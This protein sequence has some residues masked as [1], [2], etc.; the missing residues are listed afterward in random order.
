MWVLAHGGINSSPSL[1]ISPGRHQ[2]II[3]TN[4]GVLLIG[5]LGTNFNGILIDSHAFSFKKWFWKCH[6]WI[7]GI[8]SREGWV[9]GNPCCLVVQEQH[10]KISRSDIYIRAIHWYH[11]YCK[12]SILR[13]CKHNAWKWK[14]FARYWPFVREIRRSPVNSPQKGQ[15]RGAL[16]FSL[17]CAWT[18][19]WADDRRWFEMPSRSLWRYCNGYWKHLRPLGV[20]LKKKHLKQPGPLYFCYKR[21][22]CRHNTVY[23]KIYAHGFVVLCFVVVMQSFIMNSHEVFIH[24]HQGCFAGTGA[25][26]RS[27]Q[28][29]W[30]RPDGYGK[31]SQCITTTNHSKAKIVC[32]FLGIYCITCRTWKQNTPQMTIVLKHI[33]KIII[34]QY[35]CRQR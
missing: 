34:Q 28:C 19:D 23:P 35:H 5:P 9:E 4:A 8:L 21:N 14:P 1:P 29:Q 31:T 27:P 30:S 22:A 20:C 13:Q 6:L 10:D 18:N 7:A 24:I 15:R 11:Q 16:I 2:A 26:V 25:I 32:I 12:F 17:V 3:W 33:K